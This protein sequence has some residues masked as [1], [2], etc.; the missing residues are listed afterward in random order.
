ME[1]G[2]EDSDSDVETLEAEVPADQASARVEIEE[3]TTI[4]SVAIEETDHLEGNSSTRLENDGDCSTRLENNGDSSTRIENQGDYS[5]RLEDEAI[6]EQKSL[7]TEI[8][9]NK[10]VRPKRGYTITFL[11]AGES[12]EKTEKVKHVGKQ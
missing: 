9:D 12:V 11:K 6:M 3:D 1:S 2:A 5:I 7:E 10:E 8:G 4:D